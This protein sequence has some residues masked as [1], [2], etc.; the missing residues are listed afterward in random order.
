MNPRD[1]LAALATK[2]PAYRDHLPDCPLL[3]L[4]PD[5][6]PATVASRVDAL[7]DATTDDFVRR[8]F[9]CLCRREGC[10]PD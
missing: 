7:D 8:H 1:F 3:S 5:G 4:R 10:G 9:L 2:C 6:N